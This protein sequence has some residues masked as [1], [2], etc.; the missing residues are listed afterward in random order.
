MAKKTSYGNNDIV[1]LK[2]PDQVRKRPAVIFGSDGRVA[3]IPFLRFCQT[4]LTRLVR[5][6]ATK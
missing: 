3:N 4:R 2:G 5:A 6:S 1:A